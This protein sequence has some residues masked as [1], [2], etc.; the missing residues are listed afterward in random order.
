MQS[1]NRVLENINLPELLKSAIWSLTKHPGGVGWNIV[2]PQFCSFSDASMRYVLKHMSLNIALRRLR[3]MSVIYNL[4][5]IEVA[6]H[7]H[8]H[9]KKSIVSRQAQGDHNLRK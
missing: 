9:Q 8:L 7:H 3:L 4:D 2:K 5:L 1:F 6:N